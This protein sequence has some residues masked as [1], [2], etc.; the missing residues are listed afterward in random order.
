MDV[1]KAS[2]FLKADRLWGIHPHEHGDEHNESDRQTNNFRV[3]DE[4]AHVV[5]ATH[6]GLVS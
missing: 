5:E 6:R 2:R 4:S 1:P 3:A